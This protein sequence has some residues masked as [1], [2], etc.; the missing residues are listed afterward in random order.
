[1]DLEQIEDISNNTQMVK[2]DGTHSSRVGTK[3]LL[4]GCH[5]LFP[6]FFKP[7]TPSKLGFSGGLERKRS[8]FDFR[9]SFKVRYDN[10]HWR[11]LAFNEFESGCTRAF[12]K[13]AL[14]PS[15]S[16]G[17]YFQPKL[18]DQVVL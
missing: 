14:S 10:P 17:K 2:M 18:I 4:E 13:Q 11:N 16:D 8:G 5:V 12:S 7:F 9:S 3:L 15:Q 1:M 6:P